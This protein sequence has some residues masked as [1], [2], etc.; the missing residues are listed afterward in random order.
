MLEFIFGAGIKATE[1][2]SLAQKKR[3][4]NTVTLI[5][6]IAG[7]V[8]AV[9][10][11][12]LGYY[13]P[14]AVPVS[15]L[16]LISLN[17]FLY[18]SFASF[19]WYLRITCALMLFTPFLFQ[20]LIGGFENGGA[21]ALWAVF[22]PIGMIVF[23]DR[24]EKKLQRQVNCYLIGFVLLLFFS[25]IFNEFF[26]SR[27][28]TPPLPLRLGAFFVTLSSIPVVI[29][30]LL[31]DYVRRHI[32][33]QNQILEQ[34]NLLHDI[35][36]QLQK[37]EHE[38]NE[39]LVALEEAKEEIE[40]MYE[41]SRIIQEKIQ[42]INSYL[43]TILDG[44]E[45]LIIAT[46]TQGYIR[47][48]NKCAE[49]Y[50]EY[51]PEEVVGKLTPLV[52]HDPSEIKQK[53][54]EHNIS[55]LT[56]EALLLLNKH[57]SSE[58]IYISKS[59]RRYP[60]ML[61]LTQLWNPKTNVC[62][63]YLIMAYDRTAQKQYEQLLKQKNEEL[64]QREEELRQNV[65]ELR[66]IQED[67]AHKN[68]YLE[69][70]LRELKETQHKLVISEKMAAL[71][72]L[73]SGVAHEINTPVSAILATSRIIT[74]QFHACINDLPTTLEL[75][76]E[77]Q[78]IEFFA[79]VQQ[80]LNHQEKLSTKEQRQYRKEIERI[81]EEFNFEDTRTLAEEMLNTCLY[82]NLEN[83]TSLLSHPQA[84]AILFKLCQIGKIHNALT[85][86][87]IAANKA[88]LVVKAL[89]NYSHTQNTESPVTY[90]LIENIETVLVLMENLLKH[91]IEVE[92][93]YHEIP[94]L[95]GYPDQIG[96]VWANLITNAVH[97]M[98]GKG[99][100]KISVAPKTSNTIAVT[101]TD[102]G[103]GIPP[104]IQHK[105][106][107]PFFTTKPQGQGT[108]LGLDIC[109]KILEKH[110]GKISFTSEP[111]NT[112]FEVELPLMLS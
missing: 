107:D 24:Q 77:K 1:S 42:A 22:G 89:R 84:Q 111:G 6:F 36:Q 67:L 62:E 47:L 63:G 9:L 90:D 91:G 98:N 109:R 29:H 14:A 96:Q 48:F 4:L 15:F 75:M 66:A 34:Q 106:F 74:E 37:R 10:Y 43:Q 93:E 55:S 21:V 23:E 38:L 26:R 33:S 97:A 101:I 95:L 105:I 65:E 44:A 19:G 13:F 5:L 25:C 49:R 27:V 45:Y 78:K 64:L 51:K 61:S 12:S 85:N 35:I 112:T 68:K 8:W 110:E 28:I 7:L 46:D 72:Q 71:G 108:G 83:Y 3:A 52:F 16:V 87:Q 32:L 94:K 40:I 86:I 102:N 18:R 73:I 92:K 54:K 103:P 69:D 31:K 80:S 41:E 76:D 56:L 2:T 100:I 79:L 99:K 88:L 17:F 20:W 39:S 30:L 60:M 59:G 104:E 50:L 81:L 57:N 70:T 53:Q 82:K 58:W 11:G